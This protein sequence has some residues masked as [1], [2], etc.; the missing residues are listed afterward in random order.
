MKK[1]YIILIAAVFFMAV[2]CAGVKGH[3]A[4]KKDIPPPSTEK[5]NVQV[6]DLIAKGVEASSASVVT[7]K[8]CSILSERK[9]FSVSCADDAR[10]VMRMQANTQMLG[11]DEEGA[12]AIVEKAEVAQAKSDRLVGGVIGKMGSKIV[13][14]LKVT[15]PKTGKVFNREEITVDEDPAKILPLLDVAL[16]RLIP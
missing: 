4:H 9:N 13:L 3:R 10:A 16:K 6:N 15:D 5:L 14:S 12:V 1:S 8:I 2:G 11:A 7:N